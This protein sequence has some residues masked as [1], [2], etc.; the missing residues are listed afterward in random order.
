LPKKELVEFLLQ[1]CEEENLSL[2]SLSIKA[3]LSPGTVHNIIKRGY[4]PTLFSLN[5]L[6]DYLQVKR[7]HLWQLAG[8]IDEMDCEANNSF[9]DPRLKYY[10][11]LVDKLPEETRN[12]IIGVIAAILVFIKTYKET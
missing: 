9:S 7:Q 1:R 6:A 2:R 8:L 3:G 5:R 10:F 12:Q 11:S 4:E